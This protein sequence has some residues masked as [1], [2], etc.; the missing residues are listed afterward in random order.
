[1]EKK[2]ASK[3]PDQ[4]ADYE[5]AFHRLMK[6][7]MRD[8]AS[9]EERIRSLVFAI[10]DP[11]CP[12]QHYATRTPSVQRV[13]YLIG[14]IEEDDRQSSSVR[15]A[16][17]KLSGRLGI[18][19]QTSEQVKLRIA[20]PEPEE[21]RAIGDLRSEL[22]LFGF[23]RLHRCEDNRWKRDVI[24]SLQL[25]NQEIAAIGQLCWSQR[26]DQDV[27][28]ERFRTDPKVGD[29]ADRCH[30]R[31][32]DFHTIPSLE[33]NSEVGADLLKILLERM[34]LSASDRR[35]I[36]ERIPKSVAEHSRIIEA[37][38]ADRSKT[39][40]REVTEALRDHLKSW[41]SSFSLDAH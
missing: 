35:M 31:D 5:V 15:D 29:W 34:R 10:V 13:S 24:D 28:S 4:V 26:T 25:A 22:E 39:S 12:L 3:T 38:A 9:I 23:L 6:R 37:V 19:N 40:E 7:K 18:L 16:M 20:V 30:R 11:S 32:I 33:T 36:V 1:M 21:V 14:E 8:G 17:F 41:S 27:L 2:K